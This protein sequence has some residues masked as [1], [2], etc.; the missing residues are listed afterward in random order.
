MKKAIFLCIALFSFLAPL[1]AQFLENSAI[2]ALK[3]AAYNRDT[4]QVISYFGF[5]DELDEQV[6]LS[7]GSLQVDSVAGRIAARLSSPSAPVRRMAAFALGQS[8]QDS[9]SISVYESEIFEKLETETDVRT[10]ALL[11]DALGKFGS[12]TALKKLINLPFQEIELRQAAALSLARFAMRDTIL[13]EAAQRAVALY[14]STKD[15]VTEGM[16]YAMYALSRIQNRALLYPHIPVLLEASESSNP[17]VRMHAV[18]ALSKLATPK[19][20][21]AVLLA[22]KDPDWRIS[23]FAAQA[24][25]K[26]LNSTRGYKSIAAK[27]ITEL[28]ATSTHPHV[29]DACLNTLSLLTPHDTLA[30]PH[31]RRLLKS[32]SVRLR[33]KAMQTLVR[34]Y[35]RVAEKLLLKEIDRKTDTPAMLAAVG[36]LAIANQEINLDFMPWLYEHV[37]DDRKQIATAALNSWGQCWNVYRNTMAGSSYWTPTDTLFEGVLLRALKKHS[38]KKTPSPA[39]V[40]TISAILSDEFLPKK[41]YLK[42]LS[43][44]LDMFADAEDVSTIL[45]L[46]ESLGNLKEKSSVPV[47][48]KYI[49]YKDLS[50]RRKASEV[51]TLVTGKDAPIP[52]TFIPPKKIDMTPYREI[53]KNPVVRLETDKGAIEIELFLREATFTVANFMK[54]VQQ[55]FYDGLTF[56]R[57]VPN[58]VVQ[59]GDPNGDGTGGPG[60]TIRS[61]FTP[62]SFDR[63]IVGMASA[64]KDTE[65]SQFFIMHSHYPHLDG[66]YTPFGKVVRGMAVVDQI[67]VG[68]VIQKATVENAD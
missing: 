37:N 54:L 47:I 29:L 15:S 64:G 49:Y 53:E 59:S 5:F 56:H 40:K 61:E 23:A 46:L 55:G 50:V 57:V 3:Q 22:A 1:P 68:D 65:G 8:V 44:A 7:L 60:Y 52:P 35:P 9:G 2:V 21:N 36:E 62:Q 26:Y 67:E 63:G 28:L 19:T 16:N 33:N 34:A 41:K 39:A 18:F 42:V 10:K 38:A 6:L 20:I 4:K 66:Q 45:Q 43:E 32:P 11:L 12:S 58:F 31:L 14:L 51:Y 13:P 27:V 30:V 25:S 17:E 48:E 24:L